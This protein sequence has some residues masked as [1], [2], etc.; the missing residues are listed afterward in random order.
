MRRMWHG[1]GLENRFVGFE[2]ISRMGAAFE[3]AAVRGVFVVL[4]GKILEAIGFR[5]QRQQ[6]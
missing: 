3:N 6:V 1:I 4:N 2:V 5:F